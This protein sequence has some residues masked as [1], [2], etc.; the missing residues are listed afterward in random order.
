M[1]SAGFV[2]YSSISIDGKMD[3]AMDDTYSWYTESGA[4]TSI[5]LSDDDKLLAYTAN[6][7][8]NKVVK[9]AF[10]N[11]VVKAILNGEDKI[12]VSK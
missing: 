11:D 10:G 3:W 6:N 5:A 8:H 1:G 9:A 7:G 4:I 2:C 12:N